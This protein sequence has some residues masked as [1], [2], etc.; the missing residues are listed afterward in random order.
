MIGTNKL[1]TLK[2]ENGMQESWG[3]K[4]MKISINYGKKYPLSFSFFLVY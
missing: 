1:T 4:V 3:E 2:V